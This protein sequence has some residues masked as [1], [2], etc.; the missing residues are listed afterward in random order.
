MFRKKNKIS[1]IIL[2]LDKQKSYANLKAM[3][4]IEL[5]EQRIHEVCQLLKKKH[6]ESTWIIAWR[7]YGVR[8]RSNN[9]ISNKINQYFKK[10]MKKL[11]QQYPNL[12]ILAGT[13]LVRKKRNISYINKLKHFYKNIDWAKTIEDENNWQQIKKHKKQIQ[14]LE[15]KAKTENLSK[16]RV[17]SN[18]ARV[19][20]QGIEKKHGKTTP[21]EENEK[22]ADCIY[23]PGKGNNLS[24]IINLHKKP[25]N[26]SIAIDICREHIE[27]F[28]YVKYFVENDN[29]NIKPLLHFIISASM[30]LHL[31]SISASF[32]AV[33]VDNQ[34]APRIVLSR[35]YEKE[36]V[37]LHAYSCDVTKP[38]KQLHF[39]I[40]LEYP[41][42][43]KL[44]D[45]IDEMQS[46]KLISE[47]ALNRFRDDLN[48][49]GNWLSKSQL[50]RT[51]DQQSFA[52]S[53][54]NK[55]YAI[56]ESGTKPYPS[57]TAKSSF[58]KDIGKSKEIKEELNKKQKPMLS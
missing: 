2:D 38:I 17:T 16:I 43:F 7:E 47:K 22:I 8:E 31:E 54:R 26:L 29:W 49:S 1:L 23:Q 6:P 44:L 21:F 13:T 56:V 20:C 12:V 18:K 37:E 36:N 15:D 45:K 50:K 33:H 4:K 11:S 39:P 30:S 48:K 51:I 3:E 14:I 32:A 24:P 9:S 46:I 53:L 58:L 40:L 55:L 35:G 34:Y 42:Q 28:Q 5:I 19:Y 10:E 27:E 41:P 52:Y 25:I 57:Q